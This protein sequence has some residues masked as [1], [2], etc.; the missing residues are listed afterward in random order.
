MKMIIL[1]GISGAGKSTITRS[2]ADEN[3]III[4][5]DSL[6]ESL[7]ATSAAEYNRNP[8]DKIE[9]IVTRITHQ[10]VK[11]T[12]NANIIVDNTN[13]KKKYINDLIKDWPGEVELYLVECDPELAKER[14]KKRDGYSDIEYID[15]Q[16]ADL[17]NLKKQVIFDKIFINGE[18]A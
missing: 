3:F 5:R 11:Y 1:C 8:I 13:L 2:L 17:E 14:V 10:I 18:E 9:K 12:Q 7:T 4:N 6:R 16:Y 15:R